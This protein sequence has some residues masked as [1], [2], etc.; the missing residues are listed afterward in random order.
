[1]LGEKALL[2]RISTV[3]PTGSPRVTGDGTAVSAVL[4]RLAQGATVEEILAERPGLVREDVH[5]CL[6]FAAAAV[7]RRMPDAPR[8]R[9]TAPEP[10]PPEPAAAKPALRV[11]L[12]AAPPPEPRPTAATDPRARERRNLILG[13]V[14]GG[15]G[16]IGGSIPLAGLVWRSESDLLKYAAFAGAA[17]AFFAAGRLVERRLGLALAGRTLVTIFLL[18]VPLVLMV[19]DE[20]GL[21]P[22]GMAISLGIGV[23]TVLAARGL[24][25]GAGRCRGLAFGAAFYL[26]AAANLL[27]PLA[28]RAGAARALVGAAVFAGIAGALLELEGRGAA[29]APAAATLR[30]GGI[31]YA[32]AAIDIRALARLPLEASGLAT[33]LLVSCVPALLTAPRLLGREGEGREGART[34]GAVMA[35]VAAMVAAAAYVLALERPALA[36]EAAAVGTA[37]LL[38]AALREP[39]RALAAGA[40]AS[41]ALGYVAAVALARGGDAPRWPAILDPELATAY[42]PLAFA[43]LGAGAL[44][45]RSARLRP[46][47]EPPLVGALVAAGALT[48]LAAGGPL[49]GTVLLADATICGAAALLVA[50]PFAEPL[51]GLALAALGGLAWT[52][53]SF[54][55]A[56]EPCAAGLATAVYGAALAVLGAPRARGAC[57][58]VGL[59]ALLVGVC[60]AHS[61]F[62]WMA[63]AA[64]GVALVASLPFALRGA[65]PLAHLAA[66]LGAAVVG[67]IT[68]LRISGPAEPGA[69]SGSLLALALLYALVAGRAPAALGRALG[70]LARAIAAVA[71]AVALAEPAPDGARHLA[72]AAAVFFAAARARPEKFAVFAGAIAASAAALLANAHARGLAGLDALDP[73]VL[74]IAGVASTAA[75]TALARARGG[76]LLGGLPSRA[77]DFEAFALLAAT[78]AT[79]RLAAP[80]LAAMAG[81]AAP[82]PPA[83]LG[84][85][86]ALAALAAAAVSFVAATRRRPAAEAGALLAALAGALWAVLALVSPESRAAAPLAAALVAGLHLALRPGAREGAPAAVAGLAVGAAATYAALDLADLWRVATLGLAGGALYAIGARRRAAPLAALGLLVVSVAYGALLAWAGRRAGAS[87]AQTTLGIGAGAAVLAALLFEAAA[88]FDPGVPGA[89]LAAAGADAAAACT[90]VAVGLGLL[91]EGRAVAPPAESLAGAVVLLGVALGLFRAAVRLASEPLVYAGEAVLAGLVVFLRLARPDVFASGL[92]QRFWPLFVVAL[93]FAALGAGTLF[94]RAGF[95]VLARPF[96]R[97]AAVLALA[98]AAGVWLVGRTTGGLALFLSAAF[99][100]ALAGARRRGRFAILAALFANAGLHPFLLIGGF[101][102]FYQPAAF[103]GPLGLTLVVAAQAAGERLS[104]EARDLLR[105]AGAFVVLAS[106]TFSAYVDLAHRTLE[107][108]ILAALCTAAAALGARLRVASFVQLGAAFL[109]LDVASHV[110]WA[111]LDHPWIWWA[112]LVALGIAVIAFFAT[113]ERRRSADDPPPHDPRYEEEK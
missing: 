88:R 62:T 9:G 12:V 82:F 6:A 58:N 44:A 106:V 1:M 21:G 55:P 72:L 4:T 5:A 48:L 30:L 75:R 46:L 96:E 26:V 70:D 47:G 100:G 64:L 57:R 90:L 50:E 73:L 60:A 63:P 95:A 33:P 40:T 107:S 35:A 34:A 112:S 32:L 15:I 108:V 89:L 98:P 11:T 53:T 79:V 51:A 43:L 85:E 42:L 78:G 52:P 93:A 45:R 29:V 24:A 54:L 66:A 39:G 68:L 83:R 109:L 61:T 77:A 65:A 86:T 59:L 13:F 71:S 105:G 18:L 84:L 113:L 101:R 110:Y 111:G 36:L 41:A 23:P 87:E 19:A 102:Y 56:L 81:A 16:I 103:F 8:A 22:A 28:A 91:L 7:E 3:G 94:A 99:Y 69:L 17:L 104:E 2:D 25:G 20:L 97:T 74:A 27:F 31:G 38:A 10:T 49:L 14:I 67:E 80:P 37:V 76:R 92:F